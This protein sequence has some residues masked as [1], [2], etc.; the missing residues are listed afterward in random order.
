ME[1]NK[2]ILMTGYGEGLALAHHLQMEGKDVLV[3]MVDDMSQAGAKEEEDAETKKARLSQFNGILQKQ[4]MDKLL[5][6]MEKLNPEE[7]FV[8]VDFNTLWR[9]AAAAKKLGFR[10]GIFPTKLDEQMEAD[11]NFAKD[12]VQKHYP[13]VKV[14]ETREFKSIDDGLEFLEDS[15]EFWALKGNDTAATTVVPFAQDLDNVKAELRDA[16]HGDKETYERKGFIFERQIR[17]GANVTAAMIYSDGQRVA[18]N[19]DFED[20]R[21]SDNDGAEMMGCAI[22]IIERTPLDAD[23]NDVAFPSAVDALAKLHPGLFYFDAN[24]ILKDGE[25]Y[26]L[27]YCS[28]RLGYDSTFTECDMA[29]G[30]APYFN[31]LTNKEEPYERRFGV[32][33]RGF[34]TKR[35]DGK[36]KTGMTI[37]TDSDE[38]VWFYGAERFDGAYKNGHPSGDTE[39]GIDLASFTE[40]S[41]DLEYAFQKLSNVV[42]GFSFKGMYSRKDYGVLDEHR[43]GVQKYLEPAEVEAGEK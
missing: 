37:R 13:R 5:K 11:R 43:E 21:F 32:G 42:D 15:D 36:V 33:V 12:F 23:I 18:S 27:E 3:G 6:Q 26:F 10:Q 28:G 14:A 1:I 29:G 38:H 35:E 7:W 34:A 2:F 24:L 16:L 30:V 39:S 41:D 22:N 9:F 19:V 17:D 31:G 25:F 8:I 4:P 40:S 20:K